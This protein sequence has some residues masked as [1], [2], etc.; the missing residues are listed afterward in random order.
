M[1]LAFILF[2]SKASSKARSVLSG[3]KPFDTETTRD[4]LL[5]DS[6]CGT[7]NRGQSQSHRPRISDLLRGEAVQ[8]P[9]RANLVN[10]Q[11][12]NSPTATIWKAREA[13]VV[14]L[15]PSSE[16]DA[17]RA[18]RKIHPPAAPF[19]ALSQWI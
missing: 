18:G 3:K 9:G 13:F 6:Y 15:F 4:K 16:I 19:L 11:G 10:A 7:M 14:S 17:L 8:I 1:S 5:G 12:V 2:W